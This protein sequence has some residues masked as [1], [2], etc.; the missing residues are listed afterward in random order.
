MDS[1][2]PESFVNSLCRLKKKTLLHTVRRALS[3]M[4]S[5]QYTVCAYFNTCIK[6]KQCLR[7]IL[8]IFCYLVVA[9]LSP[10]CRRYV[11]TAFN[12]FDVTGDGEVEAKVCCMEICQNFA[13][14]EHDEKL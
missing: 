1:V 2:G 10:V 9:E 14:L 12:I 13:T 11:E 3:Y 5:L 6:K 8:R 4:R 7:Y